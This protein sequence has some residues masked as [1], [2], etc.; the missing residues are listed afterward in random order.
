MYIWK[1]RTEYPTMI[2]VYGKNVNETNV[3]RVLKKNE[4]KNS[5]ESSLA[6]YF[7]LL[8]HRFHKTKCKG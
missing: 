7:K 1:F 6:S 4:K 5:S 3:M 2:M 8:Y